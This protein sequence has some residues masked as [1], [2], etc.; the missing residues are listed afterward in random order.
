[1]HI[2]IWYVQIWYVP[3]I[4]CMIR[5]TISYNNYCINYISRTMNSPI[6]DMPNSEFVI[7]GGSFVGAMQDVR[8]YSTVL[9]TK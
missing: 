6:L 9:S 5:M 7:G 4:K 8:Y 2:H 1:M 3:Y